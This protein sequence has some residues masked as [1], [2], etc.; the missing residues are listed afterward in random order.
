M[1]THTIESCDSNGNKKDEFSPSEDI[2]VF[3]DGYEPNTDYT[4]YIVH[5]QITWTDGMAIPTPRLV[6][7]PVHSNESG[8]I[9]KTLVW[10]APSPG[11]YD[12]IVDVVNPGVYD[13]GVDALDNGNEITA[14]FFVIP[15]Y[16][17]GTI[18]ALTVCF[19]GVA[20]YKKSKNSKRKT[21]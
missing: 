21:L 3:G 18:L 14:G 4:L 20:V 8:H 9:Q 13:Q 19:A 10:D 16:A 11:K 7:A 15:E 6:T 17:L 12:I 1:A 5:H 2:Y